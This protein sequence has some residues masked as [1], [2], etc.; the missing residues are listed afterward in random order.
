MSGYQMESSVDTSDMKIFQL[1][2]REKYSDGNDACEFDGLGDGDEM[3]IE[4]FS[5][6]M[7]TF[8]IIVNFIQFNSL[9]AK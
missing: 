8:I 1:P 6:V 7:W 2:W 5:K 4:A 3:V 9:Q